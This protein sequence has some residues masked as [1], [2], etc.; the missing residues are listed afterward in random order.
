VRRMEQSRAGTGMRAFGDDFEGDL[1]QRRAYGSMIPEWDEWLRR[2]GDC[3]DWA[4]GLGS[5]RGW[6]RC[7]AKSKSRGDFLCGDKCLFRL[8]L[9]GWR[10][11]L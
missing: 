9:R 10:R 2:G 4:C 3:S 7:D 5:G 6:R 11:I 8:G 1:G